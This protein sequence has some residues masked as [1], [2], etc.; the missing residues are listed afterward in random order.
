MT[1]RPYFQDENISTASTLAC[2]GFLVFTA[3]LF[4]ILTRPINSLAAF[5]PANA[6]LLALLVRMP[7]MASFAGWVAAACAYIAADLVTGG[8]LFVTLWLT[9]ANLVCVAVGFRMIQRLSEED[10]CLRHPISVLHIFGICL[11]A[12]GAAAIVGGGGA[13]FLFDRSFLTG[14]GFWF[15]TELVNLLLVLPVILA[16]PPLSGISLA[17]LHKQYDLRSFLLAATPACALIA[18]II[19]G[20]VIGGPGAIVFPAPALIW[21]ALSYNLFATSVLTMMTCVWLLIAVSAS[22]VPIPLSND[23]VHSVISFRLGVTLLALGPLTVAS[24]NAARNDLLDKLDHAASYDFLTDALSRSAFMRL[25]RAAL[26]QLAPDNK[27]LTVLMLDIDHFKQVNDRYG[28]AAGDQVLMQVADIIRGIL[29]ENDLFGRL[30]GEEFAVILPHMPVRAAEAI[31]ERLRQ[32]V[33]SANIL[34]DEG[35]KIRVSVSIGITNATSTHETL[36]ERM[37]SAADTALYRA[38][39]AGRNRIVLG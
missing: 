9:M 10:R 37:L 39:S 16:A 3:S 19:A 4:G 34:L 1:L 29:R 12:S 17:F 20:L 24:I 21:C 27:P 22:L 13:I 31:A 14:I 25:G 26:S 8:T 32:D 36:L 23:F 15:I 33:E 30:G 35:T 28:H 38:K 5:W 7:R 18:S 6:L 2:V 11:V